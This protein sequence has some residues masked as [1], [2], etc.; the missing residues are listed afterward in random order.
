M[1]R[2]YLN[3]Y[4]RIELRARK[5]EG[6]RANKRTKARKI[7]DRDEDGHEIDEAMEGDEADGNRREA[8]Q[9][10]HRC[11]EDGRMRLLHQI[12]T[13]RCFRCSITLPVMDM[14]LV[15]LYYYVC[16]LM[17]RWPPVS[18]DLPVKGPHR[19]KFIVPG[20]QH[21]SY[22]T[23]SSLNESQLDVAL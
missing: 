14:A 8:S 18:C 17:H 5:A 21:V 11:T 15:V 4:S 16:M 7:N 6:I 20:S 13:G 2:A 12:I 22:L 1:G 3:A 10:A 23:S 19:P 9:L